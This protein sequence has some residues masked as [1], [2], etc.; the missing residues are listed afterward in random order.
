MSEVE[1]KIEPRRCNSRCTVIA[2][3]MLPLWATAKPPAG[4]FG[5]ERLD[6]A[7]AAAAGGGVAGVADGA[8]GP[9]GA[10]APTAW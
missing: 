6:V 1:E 9:A 5:E 10:R 8:S 7:Q 4:K 3:V 2:L